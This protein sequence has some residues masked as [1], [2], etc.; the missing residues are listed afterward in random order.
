[1]PAAGRNQV[2]YDDI[3]YDGITQFIDNVTITYSGPPLGTAVRGSA[4]VGLAVTWSQTTNDTVALT[5]DGD[6]VMGRLAEVF[7]DQFCT[8]AFHGFVQLPAGQGAA[9]TRGR[10]FVGALGPTS[11]RGYIRQT[12]SPGA[13]YTQTEQVEQ[14]RGRGRIWTVADA[15]GQVWVY[16]N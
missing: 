13:A 11:A 14:A 7:D 10:S 2:A 5:Q 8:V 1:M 6:S 12:V 15:N 3:G 9:I 16:L 4:Q